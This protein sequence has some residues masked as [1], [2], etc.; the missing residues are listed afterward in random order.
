MPIPRRATAY[1]GEDLVV[2]KAAMDTLGPYRTASWWRIRKPARI[3]SI[4][5]ISGSPSGRL[6][7]LLHRS[8]YDLPL[9]AE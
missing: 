3:L 4:K 9:V 8:S 1:F 5:S 6:S 7:A 2:R